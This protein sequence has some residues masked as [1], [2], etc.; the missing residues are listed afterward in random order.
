MGRTFEEEKVFIEKFSE[1]D[2]LCWRIAPGFV[3]NMLVPGKMYVNAELISMIYGEL[4]DFVRRNNGGNGS[5]GFLPAV[6]QIGNVASLPGIV[7]HSI[8]LPDVHAG[9]GF[10]IGNVAAF[11]CENPEAVV[12]PGRI[13]KIYL[14]EVLVFYVKRWFLCKKVVYHSFLCKKVVSL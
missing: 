5:G 1:S 2:P 6:K 14:Q 9:Y 11:D 3:P 4:R 7:G 8:G 10:A 13:N 12:S